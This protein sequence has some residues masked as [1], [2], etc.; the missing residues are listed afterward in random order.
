MKYFLIL[1]LVF[2][3]ISIKTVSQTINGKVYDS[4]S[5]AKGIKV[6][7][8]TKK[9]HTY[10]NNDGDFSIKATVTDTIIFSSLFHKEKSLRLQSQHFNETIVVELTKT[11]NELNEVL[12]SD[13][14]KPKPFEAQAYTIN[15]S[16]QI[17][18]DIKNNPHLYGKMP[19]GGLDIVQL[20]SA[21]SKL[22][23]NKNKEQ[24]VTYAS[25]KDLDSLFQC[26]NM[27]NEKLLTSDLKINLEY[28]TLFFDYCAAKNIEKTF[29]SETNEI[30]LLNKLF[31]YSEEFSLIIAEY[32]N[33]R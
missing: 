4:E 19:A 14:E 24:P 10:T 8:K 28:K 17:K 9:F 29:L 2:Q 7:N 26:K 33:K 30:D 25:Y 6:F 18:N 21:I 12:L 32:T 27:F 15:M 22:F 20:I 31:L 3:F 16:K 11:I 23:K 5:T 1:V 13:A